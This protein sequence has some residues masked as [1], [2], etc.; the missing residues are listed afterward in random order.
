MP[1]SYRIPRQTIKLKNIVK[2]QKYI[3]QLMYYGVE[4]PENSSDYIWL[5]KNIIQDTIN[6]IEAIC[7]AET[8]TPGNLAST[9]RK[10]YTWRHGSKMSKNGLQ[11]SRN[12]ASSQTLQA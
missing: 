9:S 11:N 3:Q 10:V 4:R 2:T 1:R 8:V 12:C 6:E 7:R 5:A